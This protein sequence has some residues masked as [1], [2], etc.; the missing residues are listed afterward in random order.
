MITGHHLC[1]S[2]QRLGLIQHDVGQRHS[3]FT[4]RGIVQAIREIQQTHYA[5]IHHQQVLVVGVTV[6]Q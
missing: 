4:D 5:P 3:Q 6:Y 1:T 2:R